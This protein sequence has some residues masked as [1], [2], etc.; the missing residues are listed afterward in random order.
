MSSFYHCQFQTAGS[1]TDILKHHRP[2]RQSKLPDPQTHDELAINRVAATPLDSRVSLRPTPYSRNPDFQRS[3][4]RGSFYS[5]MTSKSFTSGASIYQCMDRDIL[6]TITR[7]L[8]RSIISINPWPS[9]SEKHRMLREA[10]EFA[11]VKYGQGGRS[12]TN[13]LWTFE[14]TFFSVAVSQLD[15][16]AA[17]K[18]I[19]RYV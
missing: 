16:Q 5:H 19:S 12:L 18:D 6:N 13:Y 4:S 14:L 11:L 3:S 8:T 1:S 10:Y 2:H 9:H 7:F 15:M 17:M